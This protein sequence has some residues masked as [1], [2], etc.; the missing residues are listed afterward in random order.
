MI[1]G[2]IGPFGLLGNTQE[3]LLRE[4]RRAILQRWIGE[5]P[6]ELLTLNGTTVARSALDSVIDDGRVLDLRRKL[7]SL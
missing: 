4:I 7:V 1:D 3:C 2:G 6:E 5:E